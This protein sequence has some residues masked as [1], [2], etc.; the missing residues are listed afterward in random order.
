MTYTPAPTDCYCAV[1]LGKILTT[2]PTDPL[3]CPYC[4]MEMG[5]DGYC[6]SWAQAEAPNTRRLLAIQ[7]LIA[8]LAELKSHAVPKT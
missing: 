1:N 5:I 2:A 7:G 4:G 3:L 6:M 8:D